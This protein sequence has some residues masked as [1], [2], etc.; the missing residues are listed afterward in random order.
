LAVISSVLPSGAARETASVPIIPL[1][2]GRFSTTIVTPRARPICSAI[3]RATPS[4]LAPGGTGTIRWMVLLD[5]GHAPWPDSASTT[6]AQQAA[7]KLLI[8]AM[9]LPNDFR[10]ANVRHRSNSRK[11]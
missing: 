9:R 11:T 7:N 8:R 10:P 2:P 4:V 5:C 6:T 3:R 1:A